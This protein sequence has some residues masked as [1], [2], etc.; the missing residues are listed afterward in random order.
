MERNLPA[1]G[2]LRIPSFTQILVAVIEYIWVLLVVLDGNSVYH[3]DMTKDYHLLELSV[4]FTYLLLLLYLFLGQIRLYSKDLIVAVV[5]MLYSTVYLSVQQ[6]DMNAAAFGYMFVAGMPGLFLLFAQMYR[7]GLLM[8]LVYKLS[9]V[10]CVLAV[11]SLY[12]WIFGVVLEMIAPNM[13]TFINWGAF[14]FAPG[15]NGLHFKIQL[16]TTFFADQMLYRNS[17]IFT[18][19]PMF[20]FWLDIALA[21]ELFFKPRVSWI[22]VVLLF[23][24]V[25]TTMSVV[26]FLF[27]GLCW[28]ISII[29]NYRI[30][31]PRIRTLVLGG[32]MIA[33]PLVALGLGYIMMIKSDTQSYLMR[34]SDYTAGVKL[35]MEEP[36]FGSGYGNLESLYPYIY[37]PNGV[38]GFSNTLTGVLGTGGLWMAV[39][40][41]VPYFGMLSSRMS[42]DKG[43]SCFQLCYVFL[44]CTNAMFG[45]YI[46]VVMIALGLAVMFAPKRRS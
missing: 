1:R 6:S 29:R 45:R 32:T 37:S 19:A 18:E 8:G 7:R 27:L 15:F 40:F 41:F 24:T 35:W 9:D 20:N 42:G 34:V 23:I 38:L 2:R 5:L 33:L 30:M 22:R 44:I 11:I 16:E 39:L 43:L 21:I 10:V 13:Y 46:V 17:G 36:L 26:G 12:F 14:S 4:V 25:L 28:M 31:A 3:A